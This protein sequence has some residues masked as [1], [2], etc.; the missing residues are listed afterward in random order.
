MSSEP[1]L[2]RTIIYTKVF[3]LLFC[4]L[5]LFNMQS[6]FAH[7]RKFYIIHGALADQAFL[8]GK[9]S[10]C[11]K[12]IGLMTS[13]AGNE[14]D[15]AGWGH[16]AHHMAGYAY[17]SNMIR[18][19][20]QLEL[21]VM[22]LW[23]DQKGYEAD[24]IS[25]ALSIGHYAYITN[26][27]SRLDKVNEYLNEF[28]GTAFF[29]SGISSD[30]R[31]RIN[32]FKAFHAIFHGDSIAA[33][34]HLSI[35]KR[36]MDKPSAAPFKDQLG[37]YAA[38]AG[39]THKIQN[40]IPATIAH[41]LT[42]DSIIQHADGLKE[43]NYLSQLNHK[44]LAGY[45][46]MLNDYDKSVYHNRQAI[47]IQKRNKFDSTAHFFNTVR[48]Q[49]QLSLTKFL[50]NKRALTIQ[51]FLLLGVA[52]AII[53]LL[54]MIQRTQKANKRLSK[55]YNQLFHKEAEAKASLQAKSVFIADMSHEVRTPLNSIVSFSDML[56]QEDIDPEL[57]DEGI[58]LI[59]HNSGLLMKLINDMVDMSD[60]TQNDIN[61]QIG[62]CEVVELSR[63]VLQSIRKINH[64]NIDIR[65]KSN[66]ESL[67]ID[68]DSS[69]LQQVLINLLTNS[70]KF[71]K[72]GYIELELSMLNKDEIQF[73]VTDTGIG[74]PLEKQSTVFKRFE[75][76][77]EFSQGTG[78]G[79]SICHLIINKIG[80]RIYIDPEYTKGCR[81][82]F[83]HPVKQLSH[84]AK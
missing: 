62:S 14:K 24:Y 18:T 8:E 47:A 27:K 19:G 84:E 61:L 58:Q 57:R 36:I 51:R 77:D 16:I 67:M 65:W 3:I 64:T 74:I 33:N 17:K 52:I 1:I 42:C 23:K 2:S 50:Y 66:I 69:R 41:L 80:G 48:V 72:K 30:L 35:S 6:I 40:N 38:C 29:K 54:F 5:S 20:V 46:A 37:Y 31:L 45:Y 55:V 13:K 82:V 53:F 73:S 49:F 10:K 15:L 78:L 4:M 68:T 43:Q 12:E 71:T 76:V 60:F 79:L 26:D 70:I 22:K 21:D 34:K 59:S 39:Y 9:L 63:N 81:F 28:K 56:A 83:T 11:N 7:N 32:N 44:K 75:K 25:T